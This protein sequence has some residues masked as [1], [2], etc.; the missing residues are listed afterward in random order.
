IPQQI[1][2]R[3]TTLIVIATLACAQLSWDLA[4]TDRWWLYI[5]D[6]RSRLARSE[7]LISWEHAL[8]LGDADKN[9]L[10]QTMGFGW[11]MPSLSIVLQSGTPVRSLIAAPK[12]TS[13]QPFDPSNVDKLPRVGGVDFTAYVHTMKLRLTP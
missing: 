6:V 3:P 9:R 10:W 4:A 12:G 8:A 5:A 11:T 13:W 7:G 2:S 1:W